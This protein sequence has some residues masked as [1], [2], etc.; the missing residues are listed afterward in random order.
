VR[1]WGPQLEVGWQEPTPFVGSDA[2][3]VL[4]PKLPTQSLVVGAHGPKR[5]TL[6]LV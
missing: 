6:V 4:H 2:P 3:K 5:L 1:L